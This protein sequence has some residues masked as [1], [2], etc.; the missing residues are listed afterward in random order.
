ME[1]TTPFQQQLKALFAAN[2]FYTEPSDCW[3]YGYD[4]SRKH[5]LPNAVVFAHNQQDIINIVKLCYEHGVPLTARGRASGT[6]GAAIPLKGGV[7]LSLER[8]QT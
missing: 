2:Q 8:M 6:A 5:A 7:V 1:L 4:N 3:V